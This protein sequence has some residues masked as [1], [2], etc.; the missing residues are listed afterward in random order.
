[1]TRDVEKTTADFPL[2]AFLAI[3]GSSH[4]NQSA[5]TVAQNMY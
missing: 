5:V 1:M 4:A 2:I 3:E